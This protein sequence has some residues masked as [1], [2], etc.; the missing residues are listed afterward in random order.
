MITQTLSPVERLDQARR[1][2][3]VGSRTRYT[4]ANQVGTVAGHRQDYGLAVVVDVRFDVNSD[5]KTGVQPNRLVTSP[6]RNESQ[7]LLGA[8]GILARNG[9]VQQEH[10]DWSQVGTMPES[11]CRMDV[12]GAI[13]AA[14]GLPPYVWGEESS[15]LTEHQVARYVLADRAARTFAFLRNLTSK[16][17]AHAID[18]ELVLGDGW[19]DYS[20]RTADDVIAALVDAGNAAVGR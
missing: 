17:D 2:W 14:A 7:V 3:P 4:L 15:R 5:I 6:A 19:N 11:E 9:W 12:L 8:A 16:K 20:Y 13:A 10:I 18:V 1:H